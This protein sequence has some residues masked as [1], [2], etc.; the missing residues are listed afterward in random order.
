MERKRLV[1]WPTAFLRYATLIGEARVAPPYRDLLDA[2]E[3][4]P[5]L[6]GFI[7]GLCAPAGETMWWP[8]RRV[9]SSQRPRSESVAP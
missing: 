2:K 3:K 8:V 5:A 7:D 1:A 6:F 9:R 4:K